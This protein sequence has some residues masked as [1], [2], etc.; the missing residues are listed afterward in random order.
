M[1]P[2]CCLLLLPPTLC[3]ASADRGWLVGS[4]LVAGCVLEEL[5]IQE[6][7]TFHRATNQPAN[8]QGSSPS[9]PPIPHPRIFPD[10]QRERFD[11]DFQLIEELRR[12]VVHHQVRGHVALAE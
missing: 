8:E 3:G 10:R 2:S 4:L 9:L 1:P 7:G 5:K 11:R 12:I 6:P